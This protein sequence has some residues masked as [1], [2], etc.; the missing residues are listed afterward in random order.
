MSDIH[1]KPLR[2]SS[3]HLA[4]WCQVSWKCPRGVPRPWRQPLVCWLA[5]CL[6]QSMSL[7]GVAAPECRAPRPACTV[8]LACCHPGA[9]EPWPLALPRA[10]WGCPSLIGVHSQGTSPGSPGTLRPA[11]PKRLGEA[12]AWWGPFLR[13]R[14]DI[15][16]PLAWLGLRACCF[17]ASSVL[18]FLTIKMS[19]FALDPEVPPHPHR[20]RSMT[21]SG[22]HLGG[23]CATE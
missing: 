1:Q 6:S 7:P 11:L 10:S 3:Y 17:S 18:D 9:Q 4:P 12:P 8:A 14:L 15:F 21:L 22:R 20:L 16:L 13:R 5:R 19:M 23:H 2:T